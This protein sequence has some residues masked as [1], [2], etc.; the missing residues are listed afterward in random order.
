MNKVK[1][2]IWKKV[3]LE[4][5][6]KIGNLLGIVQLI[7]LFVVLKNFKNLIKL[8]NNISKLRRNKQKI[9]RKNKILV[10]ILILIIM[11]VKIKVEIRL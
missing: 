4:Q 6:F 7:V 10:I 9:S 3:L 1:I 2:I 11:L 5:E 8:S